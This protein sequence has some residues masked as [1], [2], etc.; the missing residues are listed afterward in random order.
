MLGRPICADL[1]NPN[2][3]QGPYGFQ[4]SGETTISGEP[5]PVANLGRMILAGDGAIS[6]YST[7]M[8]A[9]LL[10]GNPVTGTYEARSDCTISWSLQDDSGAFQH[11]SGVA[12]T[13]GKRVYFHQT[14]PG[15]AQR[16]TM[17]R[18]SAGCAASDLRKE[19]A[20]ALSGTSIPMAPGGASSKVAAK[21]VIT[22]DENANFKLALDGAPA[23]TTDVTITVDAECIADI[24]L[25]LPAKDGG[26]TTPMK[27][28]GILIDEG[29]EILAIQTDPG[30][31]VSVTFSAR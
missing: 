29:K 24:D 17:A 20:F 15:G 8:F 4:L 13:D 1:C 18:T 27:L 26:A 25:V 5:Q 22:A 6:G 9:G 31:M 21:G 19:Y 3:L 16:G 23:V 7:V 14:D 10:L 30:A 2:D 11:F 12:T 28:R